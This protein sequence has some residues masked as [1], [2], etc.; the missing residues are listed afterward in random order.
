MSAPPRWEAEGRC[1]P[2]SPSPPSTSA[3]GPGSA[4]PSRW[5]STASTSRC[6]AARRSACIG[7]NGAGK[8]TFIKCLLGISHPDS[9][10]R[11]AARRPAGGPTQSARASATCPSGSPSR[12]VDSAGLPGE[13]HPPE[14]APPRQ[15]VGRWTALLQRVG[16]RRTPRTGGSAASARA[17]ASGSG[18]P[19]RWSAHPELLVLDEPTD[20]VDPLGRVEIR[21]L[22]AAELSRGA[23]LF[24]NSHLLSE[25]ERICTRIGILSRG[26]LVRSGPAGDAHRGAAA[27]AGALRGRPHRPAGRCWSRSASSPPR[28]GAWEIAARRRARR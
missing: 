9:G 6:L 26:R 15:R 1:R 11:G 21:Q 18:S 20:G 24:I 4:A 19:R 27:L 13:R 16:P 14:G 5:R 2:P 28:A 3:S 22:L 7:P 12:G 17:C 23:T 25:T 8:T 10:E